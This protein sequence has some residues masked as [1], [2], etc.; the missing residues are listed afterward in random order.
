MWET[1]GQ[2]TQLL[3]KKGGGD[4]QIDGGESAVDYIEETIQ[5]SRSVSVPRF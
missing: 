1:K 3:K 4:K 5:A 2:M